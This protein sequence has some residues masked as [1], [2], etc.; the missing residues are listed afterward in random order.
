MTKLSI[1]ETDSGKRA[2][3]QNDLFLRT[4]RGEAVERPPVWLMR[5][6]GRILP[7]YRALRKQFPDF[8]VFVKTPD[9]AAE[10][11]VQPVDE[12]GVDAA[13]IFSDILVVPEAMGLNYEMVE[14]KGPHFPRVIERAQDVADLQSGADAAGHLGYVEAAIKQ[15]KAVLNDRVPLIG[16]AGAPWTIFAYM[17]EG[18]GSK[19]FSKARR[20][21]YADPQA[22]TQLVSENYGYN[23]YLFTGAGKSRGGSDPGV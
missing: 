4:A 14:A 12:L 1:A 18:G 17:L 5:Q 21:L 13:I 20:C 16:F 3:Y 22:R 19:T 7:Q 15:T 8:K 9:A 23:H 11:T 6:A 2:Q 10:A